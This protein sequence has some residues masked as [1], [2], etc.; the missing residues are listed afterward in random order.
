M[1]QASIGHSNDNDSMLCWTF[2]FMIV[3]PAMMKPDTFVGADRMSAIIGARS[4]WGSAEVV[5]IVTRQ[6]DENANLSVL[7]LIWKTS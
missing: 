1:V 2:G 3:I 7:H 5:A 6:E 4:H